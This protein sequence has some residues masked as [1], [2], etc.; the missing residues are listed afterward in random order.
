MTVCLKYCGLRKVNGFQLRVTCGSV[1]N[2][3]LLQVF[4]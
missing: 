1:L 3:S 4:I 2:H